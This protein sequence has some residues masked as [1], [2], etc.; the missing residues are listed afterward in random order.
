MKVVIESLRKA[1]PKVPY[2]NGFEFEDIIAS[3]GDTTIVPVERKSRLARRFSAW[4]G[5]PEGD[6]Y[7][8]HIMSPADL[9]HLEGQSRHDFARKAIWIEELWPYLIEDRRSLLS[10]K[11]FDHIFVA[12]KAAVDPI[13]TIVD[14]PCTFL[15][16]AVDALSFCPWPDPPERSID[17]LSI[18]RRREDLHK[19]LY[20]HACA[21]NRFNYIFDTTGRAP[22]DALDAHIPHRMQLAAAIKRT[23][24]F[25]SDLAK[26]DKPEQT[27]G[28]QVFG[29]RFFEGAAG[30]AILIGTPPDCDIFR[31]YF[32]WPDAIL[33]LPEGG[34][35][36]A[37]MDR[38]SANPERVDAARRSNVVGMLEAHDWSHRWET[39][40][41]AM[42]LPLPEALHRRHQALTER[43]ALV[44]QDTPRQIA[45]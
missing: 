24:F 43:A 41:Q 22:F 11:Q 10:L 7:F 23:K 30:G 5:M 37:L 34:D 6:L 27:G 18:G 39:V 3:F 16:A 40:L 1:L 9:A 15:P 45:L 13:R 8:T 25:L 2:A 20:A 36:L 26:L 31:S 44:R 4:S 33:S 17:F 21:D 12:H 38:F 42:E 32:Y 29:P 19:V 35:A 14:R 28:T